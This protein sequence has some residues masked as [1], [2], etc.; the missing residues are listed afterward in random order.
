[1]DD[2]YLIPGPPP[3]LR[4]TALGDTALL[5][6]GPVREPEAEDLCAWIDALQ[7]A[8]PDAI[9]HGPTAARLWGV[10]LPLRVRSERRLHLAVEAGRSPVRRPE[11]VCASTRFYDPHLVQEVV[12]NGPG[13]TVV[14]LA[15]LLDME[16][17]CLVL[18]HLFT[19]GEC[20][21]T[22]DPDAARAF[23]RQYPRFPGAGRVRSALAQF[24]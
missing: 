3:A 20:P 15:T 7:S 14:S 18:D 9:A 8:H 12:V 5:D 17:L 21:E 1:M 23:F 24:S 6:T 11:V 4:D 22:G 13:Q 10:P 2:M 19:H 16:E